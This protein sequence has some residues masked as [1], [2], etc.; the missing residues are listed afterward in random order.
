MLYNKVSFYSL[1]GA[2]CPPPPHFLPLFRI[3]RL[4]HLLAPNFLPS[5][6]FHA[7]QPFPPHFGHVLWQQTALLEPIPYGMPLNLRQGSFGSF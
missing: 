5:S 1:H 7:L 3:L 2:F 4:Q 6:F